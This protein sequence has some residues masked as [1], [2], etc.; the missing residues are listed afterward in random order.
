MHAVIEIDAGSM[1]MEQAQVCALQKRRYM[2]AAR[3]WNADMQME[4]RWRH[5]AQAGMHD[6]CNEM[7]AR[8]DLRRNA[9]HGGGLSMKCRLSL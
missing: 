7:K 8:A 9:A 3:A 4:H 1:I 2:Q 6:C 5:T